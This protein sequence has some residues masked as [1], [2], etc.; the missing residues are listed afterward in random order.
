MT[1]C[2]VLGGV[3]CPPVVC[4][5]GPWVFEW[6]TGHRWARG[7]ELPPAILAALPAAERDRCERHALARLAANY[8]VFGID[9]VCAEL[10]PTLRRPR[11]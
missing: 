9:E 1:C 11:C 8:R 5:R 10:A 3:P 6:W 7:D 4:S 2:N